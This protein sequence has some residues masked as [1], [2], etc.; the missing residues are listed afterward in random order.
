MTPAAK[1]EQS[2]QVS[3]ER[4]I[5]LFLLI[6]NIC[7]PI[8]R[9]VLNKVLFGKTSAR[10]PIS[11]PFVHHFNRK[12]IPFLDL[13]LQKG[14][15]VKYLLNDTASLSETLG[16]SWV[17]KQFYCRTLG[18]IRV[19]ARKRQVFNFFPLFHPHEI[20]DFLALWYTLNGEISFLLFTWRLKKGYHFRT[21]SFGH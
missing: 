5:G 4:I 7:L 15:P 8:F 11:Y 10:R 9:G 16:I 20:T 18:I 17:N 2:Y 21:T 19:R 6:Y 13:L 1:V 14:I 12:G 3:P